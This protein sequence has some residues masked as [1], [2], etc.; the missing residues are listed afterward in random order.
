MTVLPQT[1]LHYIAIR[2]HRLMR[3]VNAWPAPRWIRL[4]MVCATRGGDG[5]IWYA[6]LTVILSFGGPERFAAAAA[7]VMAVAAGIAIFLI[8]K[9]KTG[10]KRPCAIEP[11][12]WAKLLPPDQFSFPSGHTITAFAMASSLGLFY[13]SL[14]PGLLFIAVSIALSRIVLG[15]HFSVM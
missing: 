8:V 9:R 13:P 14:L 4:W 5:W 15:M 3:R 12:C 6:M 7:S 11:H 2:D 10:R 1:M